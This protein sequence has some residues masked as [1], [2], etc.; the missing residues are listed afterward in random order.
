MTQNYRNLL[1]NP[2]EPTGIPLSGPLLESDLRRTKIRLR[3]ISDE[4]RSLRMDRM[5]VSTEQWLQMEPFRQHKSLR[6]NFGT[7]TD[8]QIDYLDEA[9]ARLATIDF[10][11]SSPVVTPTKERRMEMQMMDQYEKMVAEMRSGVLPMGGSISEVSQTIPHVVKFQEPVT[12]IEDTPILAPTS[13]PSPP[14]PPPTTIT[15]PKTA[16]NVPN[17]QNSVKS[18]FKSAQDSDSE[19]SDNKFVGKPTVTAPVSTSKPATAPDISN[20]LSSITGNSKF[21]DDDSDDAMQFA[22]RPAQNQKTAAPKS[23]M[24]ANDSD[25]DDFFN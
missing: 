24:F 5:S 10:T 2:A 13:Q 15:T 6:L 14:P 18:L 8:A 17:V 3:E 1:R 4:L 19:D 11:H 16:Q 9:N 23:A 22:R 7:D 20:F 25:S 21:D 12:V